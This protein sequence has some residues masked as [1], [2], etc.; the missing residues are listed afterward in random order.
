MTQNLVFETDD[1]NSFMSMLNLIYDIHK[2]RGTNVYFGNRQ[3][4]SWVYDDGTDE[5]FRDE[6]PNVMP[7][8]DQWALAEANKTYHGAIFVIPTLTFKTREE[9]A[10]ASC[11]LR[12]NP[13]MIRKWISTIHFTYS[14]GVKDATWMNSKEQLL[15]VAKEAISAIDGDQFLA[16]F[17]HPEADRFDGSVGYGYRVKWRPSGPCNLFDVSMV[18][19]F[20]G[21]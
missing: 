4:S 20:Y 17:N 2:T 6:Q 13:P 18:H 19:M 7:V 8:G 15:G 9:A 14:S 10:A 16:E 12:Q 5:Q 3:P 21:K 1:L 11:K